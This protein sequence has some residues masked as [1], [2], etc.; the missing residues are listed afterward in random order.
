[1]ILLPLC[2]AAPI[3]YYHYLIHHD[4]Q[5][6]VYGTYRKQTY[7]N[8]CYIATAN[9][10]ETLTIP[11]EKGE[12]KTLVKDIRIASHT[13]WQTMHYRAIESAYSSSAF[14]EYF[15][16]EF[17]PLY[18]ARYK[19]LIDFNLDLQ[20]KILQCLNYQDINLSLST[21]YTKDVGEDNIDLRQEFSAKS[22][23]KLLPDIVNTPYYQVFS[24]KYGFKPNLSILDL[25]FNTAHEARIY[26]QEQTKKEG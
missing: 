15:A 16:D 4:C 8:R 12:G 9:G 18:S 7:A 5:I 19:F 20:Q 24:Y 3:A 26:L 2:Y 17:L 13:D 10:I 6:E 25:L 14:F 23:F 11:V 22:H 21:H 1:M